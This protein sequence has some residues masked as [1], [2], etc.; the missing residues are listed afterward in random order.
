MYCCTCKNATELNVF[1]EDI[2]G[3]LCPFNEVFVAYCE[4]LDCYVTESD[5]CS[6]HKNILEE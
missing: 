6:K 3:T 1:Y 2:N 5:H 4:E